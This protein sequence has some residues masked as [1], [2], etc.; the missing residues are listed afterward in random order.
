MEGWLCP[1][2]NGLKWRHLV[3][4]PPSLWWCALDKVNIWVT[5]KNSQANRHPYCPSKY[6]LRSSALGPTCSETS[7]IGVK[8]SAIIEKPSILLLLGA[9]EASLFSS[10]FLYK[11][12]QS[13]KVLLRSCCGRNNLATHFDTG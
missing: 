4:S 13:W 2:G 7:W 11:L 10:W 3:A 5:I 9:P 6:S 8:P 1:W 12:C